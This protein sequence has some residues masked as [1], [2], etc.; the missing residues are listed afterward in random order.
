MT[1]EPTFEERIEKVSKPQ[2]SDAPGQG[3]PTSVE[4]AVLECPPGFLKAHTAST[5]GDGGESLTERILE[6]WRKEGLPVSRGPRRAHMPG[7]DAINRKIM[8]VWMPRWISHAAQNYW[9]IQRAWGVKTLFGSA[10]GLPAIVVG[11]GPS[12][13]SQIEWLAK[14]QNNALIIATDASLRPLARNG[15]KPH[16]V[17]TYDCKAEQSSLFKDVDT[18][19]MVLVSNVCAHRNVLLD[20]KGKFLFYNMEHPGVPLMD[21]FL[22]TLF[23]H[24]GGLVGMGTVGNVSALLAFRM[25]CAKILGVGTDLC[26]QKIGEAYHYRCQD[27][28]WAEEDASQGLPERW[29]PLEN[30]LLYN[31]D[32]RLKDTVEVEIKGKKYVSDGTLDVYREILLNLIGQFDK[33]EFI[34]CSPNGS[35]QDLVKNLSLKNALIDYC[36]RPIEMGESVV[37]HLNKII[38]DIGAGGGSY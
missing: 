24:L 6:D 15:I 10:R 20:W 35:L 7:F 14:A 23:P 3:A 12:L 19:D 18:S 1:P 30:K 13:D 32:D 28:E 17:V 34:N 27:Y 9:P 33:E 21:Q 31:N 22:P 11:I 26:Y 8:E 2:T 29:V 4:T 5:A 16:L 25:G 36:S 38:P 37:P